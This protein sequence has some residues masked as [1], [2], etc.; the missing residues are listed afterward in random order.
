MKR[1]ISKKTEIYPIVEVVIQTQ[2]VVLVSRIM[3]VNK[4]QKLD[5]IKALIEKIFVV[6]YY[7]NA[8]IHSCV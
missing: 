6:F 2:K 3:L 1:D 5:L 4:L 8:Y 7:F